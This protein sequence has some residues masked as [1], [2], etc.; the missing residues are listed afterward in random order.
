LAK[1]SLGGLLVIFFIAFVIAYWY[2]G[3]PLAMLFY[4][5]KYEDRINLKQ[6]KTVAVILGIFMLSMSSYA[7]SHRAPSIRITEPENEFS[8]GTST[9]VTI[10]GYVRPKDS[11]LS[12]LKKAVEVDKK[13]NFEFELPVKKE[14]TI[15]FLE[16]ARED[17]TGKAELVINRTLT[18]EER[19]DKEK[20]EEAAER[21]RKAEIAAKTA[22]AKADLEAYNRSPAG[23]ACKAHPEWTK[24]ECEL[25]AA[26]KIWIGMPYDILVYR[27]GRP[28]AVNPSNYGYGTQYQ[29]CW[30]DYGPSCFYDQNNDGRIDS[31]N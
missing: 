17:K 29:Y 22:K 21:K 20:A 2:L 24:E 4:L 18:P 14:R 10:K 31:Y 27:L 9:L 26:G 23:R 5:Y 12:H 19:V 11:S 16:T 6:K 30:M 8:V 13:G 1:F 3:I 7:Y 25:L 28:D 15:V